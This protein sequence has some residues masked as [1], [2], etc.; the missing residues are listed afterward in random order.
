MHRLPGND[1]MLLKKEPSAHDTFQ[2]WPTKTRTG[3]IAD[4]IYRAM[5]SIPVVLI[6][7]LSSIT[8]NIS[9]HCK[10]SQHHSFML[11]HRKIIDAKSVSRT[12]SIACCPSSESRP[13]N[14]ASVV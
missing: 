5:N 10:P 12:S 1:L 8:Y 7:A 2:P 11:E 3:K 14:T 13:N 4:L 9:S 6:I